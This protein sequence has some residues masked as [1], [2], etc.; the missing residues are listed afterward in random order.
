VITVQ[1][2]STQRVDRAVA[3][4]RAM[5]ET[6]ATWREYATAGTLH[7]GQ[8]SSALSTA[9]RS[10]R[11]VRLAERRDGCGVYVAPEH[12]QGREV[13]PY[14]TNRALAIPSEDEL[15]QQVHRWLDKKG[16]TPRDFA[17]QLRRHLLWL[18]RQPR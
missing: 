7:H 4:V 2:G 1:E 8:A 9:Q 17:V 16:S 12:L 5:G 15:E 10:G 14:R 11:L 6:G 18:A 3:F 13:A